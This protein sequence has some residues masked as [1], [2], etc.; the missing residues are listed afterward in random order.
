MT[1]IHLNNIGT[2]LEPTGYAK[3][4]RYL[5]FELMKL[6]V[7]VRFTPHHAEGAKVPLDP[8]T[9]AVIASLY[10]NMLANNHIV[11]FNFPGHYFYRHPHHYTI[12]LTM[13]ELSGLPP[14]WV[15]K[16]NEMDEIW[17]P[18]VFN[19]QTFVN[20]GVDPTKLHVM[21]LGVDTDYFRPGIPPLAC[22]KRRSYA[23]LTVCSFD[24]RKGIDVLL[25][26]FF[27]EFSPQEDVSLIVK[28]R[29]STDE[30][31][32]NQQAFI[33]RI[34]NEVTGKKSDSVLLYSSIQSWNEE[35]MLRLY[36]TADCYVLPTRGEGWSMTVMEAMATGLPV[37]TTNWSAHV[38]FVN[39]SNGYLISVENL[40]PCNSVPSLMWAQPSTDH[41][42][43]LMRHV[44]THPDEAQVKVAN[45]MDLLR[46]NYKWA[47]CA[48]TMWRRLQ[49]IS[50][51]VNG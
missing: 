9:E 44:Y 51:Q 29:A 3:A 33:D 20:S 21:P 2:M 38:D 24:L 45:G 15:T 46:R 40:I 13:F 8:H 1:E 19:Q 35:D 10:Q 17:V 26:A 39:H 11:L 34:S 6:G 36:N 22:P 23:F 7:H 32:Q 41:L 30:E 27:E 49:D 14:S 18:S 5:M 48:Q 16:C 50:R 37:I 31:I 43:Q 12:G 28:T 42:K 25:R 47:M 4:N